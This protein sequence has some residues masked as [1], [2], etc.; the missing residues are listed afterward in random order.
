MAACEAKVV[1][2]ALEN[3]IEANT[4]LSGIG[5]VYKRQNQGNA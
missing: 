1:T 3:I 2:P 4:L 5:D